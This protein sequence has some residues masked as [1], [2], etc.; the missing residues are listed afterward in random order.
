MPIEFR[1]DKRS[2]IL[3]T[4][5]TGVVSYADVLNHIRREAEAG[6]LACKELFDATE[7]TTDMTTAEIQTV[8]DAVRQRLGSDGFGPTAIVT[9]SDVFFGMSRMLDP[10]RSARW[11]AIRR[12]QTKAR[13]PPMA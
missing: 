3:V 6:D 8:A 9:I 5:A 2:G 1:F 12:F 7:A 11:S 13:R 4:T 10:L